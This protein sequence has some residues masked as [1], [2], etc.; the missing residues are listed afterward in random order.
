MAS[1]E[2]YAKWMSEQPIAGVAVWAHTGRGLLLSSEQRSQILRSWRSALP[3]KIVIAGAG[4]GVMSESD[5]AYFESAAQMASEAKE[6]GADAILCYAPVRF[7][8]LA[9]AQRDKLIVRYHEAIASVGLP[10]ILFYLYEAAGGISYSPE[11]LEELMRLDQVIGIKIATLDSIMTYQ[12]VASLCKHID[13]SKLV[14]TGEDRFLGYSLMCGADAA[15]IGMGAAYTARQHKLLASYYNADWSTFHSLSRQIDALAQS[16]FIQS[17][18]GYI[19][20]MSYIL[21]K[22]GLFD[23]DSWIDL[24]GPKI[25]ASELEGIDH[26]MLQLDA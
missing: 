2:R 4:G 8:E 1:Q 7:R 6:L 24:W 23:R 15:L 13:A 26:L 12:D 20:R 25:R 18:E 16:T 22:Q 21:S 19:A 10:M 17:M 14:I 11:V 3:D 5:D 9:A